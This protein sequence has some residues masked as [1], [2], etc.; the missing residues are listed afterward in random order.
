MKKIDAEFIKHVEST[1]FRTN[2]DTGANECALLVWNMVRK[3]VGLPRLDK[4]DL[5]AYCVVHKEYH[6]INEDYGCKR[7]DDP[8][9][10]IVTKL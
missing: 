9:D 4:N 1:Q 5:P 10:L 6:V 2:T 7:K 3:H 8:I